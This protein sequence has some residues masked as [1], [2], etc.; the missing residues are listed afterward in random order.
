M[1]Q[2]GIIAR[3]ANPK[4]ISGKTGMSHMSSTISKVEIV[5]KETFTHNLFIQTTSNSVVSSGTNEFDERTATQHLPQAD[6]A[7]TPATALLNQ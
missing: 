3:D 6:I 1:G 2:H 5:R 4:E 7:A